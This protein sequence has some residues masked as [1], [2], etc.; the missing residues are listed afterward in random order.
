MANQGPKMGEQGHSRRASQAPKN[1]DQ[2]Y[3]LLRFDNEVHL[4]Y[5]VINLGLHKKRYLAAGQY[6]IADMICYP[7]AT[8]WQNRNNLNEFSNVKR[9]LDEIGERPAV[10]KAMAAGLRRGSPVL[11]WIGTAEG[12]AFIGKAE[13]TS[14]AATEEDPRRFPGKILA[15][16]LTRDRAVAGRIR[17]GNRCAIV[18]T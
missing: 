12:P 10:K 8:T 6:T 17:S 1:G 11:V 15:K 4:I 14:D 7:S 9:W 13:T 16:P 5:G 2:A 3:A 18:I